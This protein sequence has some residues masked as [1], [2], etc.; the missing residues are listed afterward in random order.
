MARL[1]KKQIDQIVKRDMPGHRVVRHAKAEDSRK[2]RVKPDEGTPDMA[3]LRRK[4]LGEGN[5][6]FAS[7]ATGADSQP[8]AED[9][10]SSDDDVEDEMVT[11]EPVLRPGAGDNVAQ[12]K[13]V[14]ISGRSKRI[15]A[16]QG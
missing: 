6:N 1:S 14:V 5:G 11:L 9:A 3:A 2:A 13:V 8:G 10:V 4:Y 12:A 15:I 7:E 16:S